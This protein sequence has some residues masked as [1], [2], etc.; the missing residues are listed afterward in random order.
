MKHCFAL[1]LILL[2]L[3]GSTFTPPARIDPRVLA[4]TANGATARFIVVLRA[5]TNTRALV[6][7]VSDR[8]ARGRIVFDALRRVANASQPAVRAQLDA[9][10]ARY[11]AF[12]VINALVVE[13]NRAVVDALAA[14]ADVLAIESDRAFRVELARVESAPRAPQ[15][16]EWN[17]GK[18]NVPAVWALG[19]TGQNIVY[20]NADTGVQWNHPALM[21][22]YRGWN[23]AANHNYNWW[24]A[25]HSDLSGN[26]TNP[27]GYNLT[28]P[29]DDHG[30]GTH[31][32]GTGVGDDG[33]GNQI[34][35]APGARWIACRN[36]E[37]GY[38]APS[39]YIECF[40][41]FLA[42]WDLNRQNPDPDKR[43]DVVG[44]SYGCPPS[45]GCSANSLLVAMD[46]LR[47]AG[48]FMAVAAG[49][50]GPSCATVNDPPAI[51]DSAI[52]IGATDSSDAIVSFSSRGPVTIDGSNRRKPDFVAP[53]VGIR[54]SIPTNGYGYSS[55]TSMATPHVAGAVAL[56]WSAFPSLRRNVD[57][58]ESVLAIT[59]T[60]LPITQLCGD[61]AGQYPNNV[62]GHGRVDVRAA[63]DYYAR[64]GPPP[65][66]YFF[67]IVIK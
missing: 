18:I 16:V 10:G 40:D 37:E 61:D 42:P 30:H 8:A 32:M 35:V 52:S 60:R 49:N 57:L 23:G 50:A 11:R 46:N 31:V 55:G 59:A 62:Q 48:I 45:E 14:R 65:Y 43:P 19:Y 26:G 36:M 17:I 3:T 2:I 20:A 51:Y 41:F 28:A 66:V 25:I 38:G 4:D 5:Q 1:I 7:S 44:N 39:T 47:A 12:T 64:V 29:C 54:S 21:S 27:C 13:G 53:G 67:P 15:G 22:K 58:T 9:L 33:A 6:A 34:G 63:Y 56:L 24:D